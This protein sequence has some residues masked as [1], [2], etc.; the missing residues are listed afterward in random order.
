MY[1]LLSV[2]LRGDH[3][4]DGFCSDGL[5]LGSDELN[6]HTVFVPLLVCLLLVDRRLMV[7]E[8]PLPI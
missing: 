8:L 6:H 4:C 5:V 2:N 7:E 3:R 1:L